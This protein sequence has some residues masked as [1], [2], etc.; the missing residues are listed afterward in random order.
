MTGDLRGHNHKWPYVYLDLGLNIVPVP[1]GSKHPMIPWKQYTQTRVT[2]AMVDSWMRQHPNT[3][4]GLVTGKIS[5]V[6]VLDIDTHKGGKLPH[7]ELSPTPCSRTQSGGEHYFFK[8]PDFIVQNSA[9]SVLGPGIDVRGEGGLAVMPPSKGA[10]GSYEW[11][12]EPGD[13]GFAEA[14]VWLLD[15]LNNADSS[16]LTASDVLEGVAEGRRNDA[17]CKYIGTLLARTNQSDWD[18]FVLP[19]VLAWNKENTPPLPTDELLTKY[20]ALCKKHAS[21]VGLVNGGS[22]V[23][24][25]TPT[26]ITMKELLELD[27]PP[28]DWD[29]EGLIEHGTPNMLSAPPNSYKSW[30]LLHIAICMAR[31]EKLFGYFRTKKQNV[32]IVNEEDHTGMLKAR[33]TMLKAQQQ[34]E[35]YWLIQKELKLNDQ[36]VD[37]ILEEIERLNIGCVMFDSLRTMHNADEN[38]SQEMQ[39]VMMS[40]LK[41]TSRGVTVIFT[42]HHRKRARGFGI[43][44]DETGEESRGS[45]SIN[46][47]VHG[48]LSCEPLVVDDKDVLV[49]YQRK[50]KCDAKLP[51]FQVEIRKDDMNTMNFI[52][53]GEYDDNNNLR[54]K[55]GESIL[56][57]LKK[58]NTWLSKRDICAA[59]KSVSESTVNKSIRDLEVA[60]RIE[61]RDRKKLLVN[62]ESLSKKEGSH[63][64]KFYQIPKEK[65]D[66]LQSNLLNDDDF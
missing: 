20:H 22:E 36:D 24:V 6:F 55:T 39:K 41:L 5:G 3:G 50:L 52:Y 58:S 30:V 42:H 43:K 4:W 15:R 44:P 13:E 47:A 34:D 29:V 2:K 61:S 40:I 38:N 1:S 9:G 19:T 62:K 7:D 35:I 16:R 10:A 21:K 12:I 17:A 31:G 37:Y 45:S 54:A 53:D 27:I 66:L 65:E 14:P 8:C 28:I 49:L 60:G 57:M 48:H 18:S 59:I 25:P 56:T 23:D 33:S 63:Q 11:I 26:S 46:A 51:A 32:L 64:E